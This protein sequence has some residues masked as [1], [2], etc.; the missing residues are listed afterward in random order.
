MTFF[1]GN[2][3]QRP[4]AS[5]LLQACGWPDPLADPMTAYFME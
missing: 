2:E 4:D 5:Q 1:Y 3:N